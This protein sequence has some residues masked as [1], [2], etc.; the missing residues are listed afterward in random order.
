MER[1]SR[2]II[3]NNFGTKAQQQLCAAKVLV[4]GAGGLGCP[5]LLY[6]A[7]AGIGTIGI[8]DDDKVSLSNLHRQVLFST[9][10]IDHFKTDCAKKKLTALNPEINIQ[11]ITQQIKAHN[12]LK[13]ITEYDYI[14]DG[15]DNF[16]SKYLINDACVVAN[17]P[18]IYGAVSQYEGQVAVFN[19]EDENGISTNYRDLFI[20][21]PQEDKIPNCAQAGVLG[22]LPGII[23]AMQAAEVIK[24]ITQI[25]IPLINQLLTYNVLNQEIYTLQ[26]Q[27]NPASKALSSLQLHD[28]ENTQ[29]ENISVCSTDEKEINANRFIDLM[30]QNATL[31]D[32]REYGEMPDID[33]LPHL[34]IPLSVLQNRLSEIEGDKVIFL[35]RSGIRSKKALAIYASYCKAGKAYSL[36]G[37]IEQLKNLT[38]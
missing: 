30:K 36:K 5:A 37:G 31:V 29:Y 12:A 7:G 13:I 32:V 27:K 34:H 6:L 3:L 19:V 23:G 20:A 16:L 4:I 22:V 18:L 35:C 25:G 10:D 33:W 28:F 15:T 24:L 9:D 38:K 21:P 26:L 14:I 17:K 11:T 2:Q 8:V 1:Y